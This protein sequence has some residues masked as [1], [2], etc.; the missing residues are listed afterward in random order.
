MVE[1]TVFLSTFLVSA[2]L[3]SIKHWMILEFFPSMA[4][5]TVHSVWTASFL[6]AEDL[7]LIP[8]STL[9]SV[10]FVLAWI[11]TEVLWIVSIN[12]LVSVMFIHVRTENALVL[13]D[14]EKAVLFQIVEK[15]DLDL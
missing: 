8:E 15:L 9:N 7:T 6:V 1:R 14:V 5:G 2:W 4:A 10:V 12:T 3:G 13:V 11:T